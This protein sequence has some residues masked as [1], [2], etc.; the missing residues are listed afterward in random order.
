MTKA[1]NCASMR[2]FD[3]C[4]GI[5]FPLKMKAIAHLEVTSYSFQ[6]DLLKS[7]SPQVSV[8][9]LM[10][11]IKGMNGDHSLLLSF[12]FQASCF[13]LFSLLDGED[14]KKFIFNFFYI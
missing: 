10:L 8:L 12:L 5:N 9:D 1:Q 4:F 14:E 6:L 13:V 3:I 11:T 2:E 7:L